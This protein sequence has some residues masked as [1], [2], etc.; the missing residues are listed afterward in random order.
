[1]LSLRY[2]GSNFSVGI[3]FHGNG[4]RRTGAIAVAGARSGGFFRP[5]LS[6]VFPGL[7]A[8]FVDFF[9]CGN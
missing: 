6:I 3:S 4:A 5:F 9:E 8:K 7:P 1:M 2:A